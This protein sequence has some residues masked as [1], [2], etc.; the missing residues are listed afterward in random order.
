[1]MLQT[2][3]LEVMADIVGPSR[4]LW[5]IGFF[6]DAVVGVGWVF[7]ITK[8]PVIVDDEVTV[9]EVPRVLANNGAVAEIPPQ[10]VHGIVDI[11]SWQSW[12]RRLRMTMQEYSVRNRT[13]GRSGFVLWTYQWCGVQ[14]GAG[15]S[16]A[17]IRD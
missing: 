5:E 16:M 9:I 10:A 2:R 13:S 1:M 17:C 15:L 8:V 11:D 6:W 12:R 7:G 14:H 3:F 4:L